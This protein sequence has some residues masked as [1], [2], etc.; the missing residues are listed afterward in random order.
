MTFKTYFYL[1]IIQGREPTDRDW[2]ALDQAVERAWPGFHTELSQGIPLRQ[3]ECRM[4]LL[5]KVGLPDKEIE[6]L[7]GYSQKSLSTI[8]RRVL[9][10]IYGINGPA[11][12]LKQRIRMYG[13]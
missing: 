1:L 3:K 8:K 13:H 4:C 7:L 10:K 12:E 2:L 9:A 5:M 11:K 6:Y